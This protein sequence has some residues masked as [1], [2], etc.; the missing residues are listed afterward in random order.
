[1]PYIRI[2]CY[3]KVLLLFT[4]FVMPAISYSQNCD[5]SKLDNK[6]GTSL[7]PILSDAAPIVSDIEERGMEIV[8]MEFD[9][10]FD[11]KQVFRQLYSDWEYGIVAFGDYRI[12]DIDVSVSKEV[13]G[14]WVMLEEDD[15]S[16]PKA[17][18]TVEPSYDGLYSIDVDAYEFEKGCDAG[19]FGVIIFHE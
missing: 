15:S 2:L 3:P 7:K 18:V 5:V 10:I 14:D 1:M 6:D 13:D 9:I 8:R 16:R 17:A 11:D 19:R 12:E 4:A